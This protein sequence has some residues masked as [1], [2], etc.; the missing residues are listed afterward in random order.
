MVKHTFYHF[1]LH[2]LESDLFLNLIVY[3]W[4]IH[5][6]P[7]GYHSFLDFSSLWCSIAISQLLTLQSKFIQNLV[8]LI[9]LFLSFKETLVWKY[10]YSKHRLIDL[11]LIYLIC[12]SF[13]ENIIRLHKS[14][15]PLEMPQDSQ[16]FLYQRIQVFYQDSILFSQISFLKY[17]LLW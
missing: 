2:F 14:C 17:C 11:T 6:I 15:L 13:L 1:Y 7:Q 8:L 16:L 12:L 4:M 3:S 10:S 5:Y 9:L